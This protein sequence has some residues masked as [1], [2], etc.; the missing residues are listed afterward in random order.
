MTITLSLEQLEDRTV[1][2]VTTEIPSVFAVNPTVLQ[3]DAIRLFQ[4]KCNPPVVFLGDSISMNLQ[5]SPTW[6]F[7]SDKGAE[8]YAVSGQT[9]QGLLLQLFCGQLNGVNPFVVVLNMGGN[10][11]LQGNTPQDTAEG[12]LADVAAIHHY[13]PWTQVVVEG[14]QPGGRTPDVPY[15]LQGAETNHIVDLALATDPRVTFVDVGGVFLEPN[16]E[17]N[18][19]LINTLDNIHPTPEGYVPYSLALLPNVFD[20]ALTSAHRIGM[21]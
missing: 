4:E 20:A 16:G 6:G 10:N 1:P 17:L 7:W 12:I 18:P 15:R 5:L 2:S 19:Y 3:L 11:L 9:T 8:N 21:I 13:L 14:V